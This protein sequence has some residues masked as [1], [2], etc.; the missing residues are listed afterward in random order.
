MSGPFNV[1]AHGGTID[2]S[3]NPPTYTW[4]TP[5]AAGVSFGGTNNSLVSGMYNA[6]GTYYVTVT[7]STDETTSTCSITL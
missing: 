4:S 5:G 1:S 3:G 6:T 7:A 2:I